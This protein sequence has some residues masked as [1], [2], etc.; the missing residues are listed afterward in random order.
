MAKGGTQDS[1][2]LT[3]RASEMGVCVELGNN[4][5][6]IS[7]G[8]KG[9]DGHM[10]RT[11]KEAMILYIGTHYSEDISKEFGAGVLLVLTIPL[12]DA[13]ISTRHAQRVQ[14][15][16]TQDCESL[17]LAGCNP[18]CYRRTQRTE[19]FCGRRW[20]LKTNSPRRSLSSQRTL[21]VA[22]SLDKKAER[23]NIYCTHR[24]DEQRLINIGVRSTL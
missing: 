21:K 11:T 3:R 17:G 8:N 2:V 22:P 12:Q 14:V 10:L 5:F 9:W 23:S 20:R 7:L 15:H 6:T 19:A 4:I 1:T 16:K 13:A 24:E 18:S